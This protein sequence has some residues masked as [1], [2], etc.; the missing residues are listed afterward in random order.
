MTVPFALSRTLLLMCCLTGLSAFAWNAHSSE[1]VRFR[2]TEQHMGTYF[3]LTVYARDE[4]QA[5]KAL[6]AA[7]GQIRAG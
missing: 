5:E 6:A 2:R 7:F 1:L 3:T 4:P